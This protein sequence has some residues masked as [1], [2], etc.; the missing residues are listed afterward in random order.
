VELALPGKFTPPALFFFAL[1]PPPEHT[2]PPDEFPGLPA[3]FLCASGMTTPEPPM[4]F[5][6]KDP[7]D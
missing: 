7:A 6:K 1:S 4:S 3:F 2:R 5:G